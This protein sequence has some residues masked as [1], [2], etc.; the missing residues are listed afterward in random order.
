MVAGTRRHAEICWVTKLFWGADTF[1]DPWKIVNK[2]WFCLI[3]VSLYIIAHVENHCLSDECSPHSGPIVNL[4][5]HKGKLV[6]IFK[7]TF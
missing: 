7:F 4:H 6:G 3:Q 1:F 2:F 5:F